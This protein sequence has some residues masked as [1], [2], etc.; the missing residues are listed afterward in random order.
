M[1]ELKECPFCG[2]E[3][4]DGPYKGGHKDWCPFVSLDGL[5]GW[6]R[7]AMPQCVK[8]L[9]REVLSPRPEYA[10]VVPLGKLADAVN[11]YYGEGG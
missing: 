8:E 6:N 1:S 9:V 11:K 2:L 4:K 10:E 3:F 7:R 5:E